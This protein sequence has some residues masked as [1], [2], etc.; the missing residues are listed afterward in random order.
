MRVKRV[1]VVVELLYVLVDQVTLLSLNHAHLLVL[2]EVSFLLILIEFIE[3][4]VVSLDLLLHVFARV[5]QVVPLNSR[6]RE[7]PFRLLHD[8]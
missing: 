5:V 7:L 1:V 6:G 3:I 8:L 4:V 2:A